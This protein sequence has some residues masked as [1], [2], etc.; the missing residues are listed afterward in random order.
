M[1]S[2]Y[3]I[4]G[5]K[6]DA[7]KEEIVAAY[8]RRVIETHP[9]RGG[10]PIEFQNVRKGYEILSDTGTR[11]R[12]DEWIAGKENTE[13]VRNFEEKE[14]KVSLIRNRLCPSMESVLQ[15][16]CLDADLYDEIF[17]LYQKDHGVF[18]GLDASLPDTKLVAAVI[19][20]CLS[21][22]QHRAYQP[23]TI[24]LAYACSQILNSGVSPK[25]EVA[26][27]T[28]GIDKGTLHFL[29]IG[30]TIAVAIIICIVWK[31][32]IET[33]SIPPIK[34]FD[35]T[36][37]VTQNAVDTLNQ[38]SNKS[39]RRILY[40]TLIKNGYDLG[41]YDFF[42]SKIDDRTI[43][44]NFYDVISQHYDLGSYEDFSR[45]LDEGYPITSSNSIA[46]P[47]NN[48]VNFQLNNT[49][50]TY[51]ETH[52]NTGNS[53]YK[54]YFGIGMFDKESLSKLTVLNYSNNDA[55]ILL[56]TLGNHVIRNVFIEQGTTYTL[57]YIPEGKY[58][59]KIMYGKSWNKEKN[60]GSSFPKG[61]FMK[62]VS[63]SKTEEDDLF[64]YTFEKSY[65]GI[66]YPAYSITLHK[67]QNG[68]LQMD[69]ISQSDFFN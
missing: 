10:D 2:F 59:V 28:K 3:E 40:E 19:L 58:I 65:D 46:I 15:M 27:N 32:L 61:G 25:T 68:N 18:D 55:V 63:F 9:D 37:F 66:S 11:K 20:R 24:Q 69:N 26:D 54:N 67:V 5:V 16:Y 39:K 34:E 35:R 41:D 14:Q 50:P 57:M 6:R 7:T 4:L 30:L 33:D 21:K 48:T 51:S 8:R 13:Q 49:K 53:P 38:D 22:L 42:T 31:T 44:R 1:R 52:F 29:K 45:K 12:Y 62:N 60:N 43:R 23:E 36:Q 56:C 64:D 47:Q 17:Q